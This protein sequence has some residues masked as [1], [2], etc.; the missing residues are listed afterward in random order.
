M[1]IVSHLVETKHSHRY[2]CTQHLVVARSHSHSNTNTTPST[3]YRGTVKT[4]SVAR[5][6]NKVQAQSHSELRYNQTKN[7]ALTEKTTTQ[8]KLDRGNV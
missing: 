6:P 5:K 8:T 3:S 1:N 4:V 2:K 7:P